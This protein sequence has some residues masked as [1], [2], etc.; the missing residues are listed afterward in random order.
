MAIL[1]LLPICLLVRIQ[2][3]II[4][5]RKK[6]F[7]GLQEISNNI[8]SISD[9]L[10]LSGFR[11]EVMM[12]SNKYYNLTENVSK[13]VRIDYIE[14]KDPYS[15]LIQE[16][17]FPL[18]FGRYLL[19]NDYFFIIWNKTFL[20][21][22]FDL[23]LL[24]LAGKKVILMHCGDD[25]RYRPLQK[26]IDKKYS[27]TTWQ[28]DKP[29]SRIFRK[30]FYYQWLCEFTGI[31]ISTRDQATFQ[32]K[33][34][35]HF[36][37][38]QVALL[39][40]MKKVNEKCLIVHCPSNRSVK[41]T[42]TVLS[43]IQKLREEGLDFEFELIENQSNIYVLNRLQHADILI[44]QPGVWVARLAVEAMA[45]GCCVIGG[46]YANYMNRYDSPVIQFERSDKKL[47]DA[48]RALIV[49]KSIRQ[50]NMNACY[51]FWKEN[52]SYES[53]SKYFEQ[54]CNGIA[55]HF[56]PLKD[57]KNILFQGNIPSFQKK[58]IKLF[59]HPRTMQN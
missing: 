53:Y 34:L 35:F 26:L 32:N 8:Y 50:K 45:A 39:P 1:L 30:N 11:C 22:S 20:L 46:N 13:R 38:P 57:Q 49:N 18:R 55:P 14:E 6:V 59:Y 54:V 15:Y 58:I 16:M 12:I 28:N 25:V 10:S 43:A 19:Q 37:F 31:T 51:N 24:K 2:G 5:R 47:A 40:E 7:I 44:D 29:D 52:Y 42:D 27:L 9:C 56:Y 21:F 4:N 17:L 41:G 3:L 48:L 33:K 36:C 23:V